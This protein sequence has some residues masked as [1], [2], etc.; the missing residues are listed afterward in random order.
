MS[1]TK[2]PADLAGVRFQEPPLAQLR[3]DGLLA[4]DL[5]FHTNHSDA[6][7]RVRDALK[8]A[9]KRGVGVAIT[10][11]NTSSGAVEAHRL[12]PEVLVVPGMEI[13]ASD[14]PHLLVY[15]YSLSEMEEFERREVAPHKGPSPYLA[16]GRTTLE[17]LEAA[18]G[19]NAVTSA[20]HP[21]GYLF[22]NK[23]V[24]KSVESGDV[25]EQA[26]ARLDAVE[27]L[28]G[29]M[30]RGVNRRGGGLAA[31]RE[32]AITGG[33]DAHRLG[34]L[35]HVVTVA[36][37]SDLDGFL[38]AIARGQSLAVGLEKDPF[39]KVATATL[40]MARFLPHTIP[41]LQVHYRQN[42]PR[43][44]RYLRR[45]RQARGQAKG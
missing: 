41:S 17:L 16:T 7:T 40:L 3:R 27:A 34:D 39:G 30:T 13:T 4:V 45:R 24:G 6:F 15:F 36:E 23:G 5:H 35:G 29:S 28:N 37:A 8:L 21:Y 26:Y 10:D 11:H 42:A 20:A 18:Q 12:D 32:L 1:S 44:E 14:G 22:F 19:Y 2:R 43:V 25:A 38:D 31:Q 9:R 33:T